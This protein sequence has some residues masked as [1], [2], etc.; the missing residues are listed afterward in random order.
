MHCRTQE[1]VYHGVPTIIIPLFAEQ[2]YN[3]ERI[4]MRK[5][6]V[7]IDIGNLTQDNLMSAIREI[8]GNN[9]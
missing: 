4:Q 3:A 8:L 9:L 2:D 7:M 1:A 5:R 6:G